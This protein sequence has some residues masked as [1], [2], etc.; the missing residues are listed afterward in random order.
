MAQGGKK[1][2]ENVCLRNIHGPSQ[3]TTIEKRLDPHTGGVNLSEG[4]R[5]QTSNLLE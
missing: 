2:R 3:V 1:K 5:T 4:L